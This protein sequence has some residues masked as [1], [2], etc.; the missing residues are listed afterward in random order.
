MDKELGLER[1]VDQ[2]L[3]GLPLRRAPST[4]ES[5]VINELQRRA[6]LP[7]WRVSFAHWPA[8]P[9]VAFVIICI[10][11]V[12]ATILGGVSAF[13]GVGSLNEL[14]AL[15]LSWAHPFLAVL[16]SAGGV[17]ALLV[18]IIPP[19]WLYGGMAL[20]IVLYVALFGL[21]AAAYRTLYLQPS[22][23]GGDL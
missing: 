22:S 17:T 9:R 3:K 8:A 6:A 12:A 2:A 4:L 23:V 16:S 7:W 19:L 5:R 10:A 11:L 1:A 13:V 15:A 20:G 18:H 21:G 14:A